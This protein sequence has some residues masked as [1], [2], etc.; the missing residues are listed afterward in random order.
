MEEVRNSVD[1]FNI[2]GTH[3]DAWYQ[4]G[5]LHITNTFSIVNNNFSWNTLADTFWVDQPGW[6]ILSYAVS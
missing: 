2:D 4:N 3:F 6:A 5:P 1:T